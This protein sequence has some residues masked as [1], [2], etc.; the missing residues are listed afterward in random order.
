MKT[1]ENSRKLAK[2]HKKKFA[3]T[4]EN[5]RKLAKT[6]ENSRK[7]AK[8]AKTRENSRKFAKIVQIR[9]NSRP[10]QNNS[11]KLYTLSTTPYFA[12]DKISSFSILARLLHNKRYAD[13]SDC[14]RINLLK[15]KTSSLCTVVKTLPYNSCLRSNEATKEKTQPFIMK[16]FKIRVERCRR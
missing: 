6:R 14:K 7:L 16:I 3:K 2:T 1:R 9:E 8:L 11:P 5:S 12:S 10:I 15:D 4:R 13:I